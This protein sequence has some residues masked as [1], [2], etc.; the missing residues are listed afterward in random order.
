MGS[1]Y[2]THIDWWAYVGA[3]REY[4]KEVSKSFRIEAYNRIQNAARLR[5]TQRH[6][7]CFPCSRRLLWHRVRVEVRGS[8][9]DIE[10]LQ[11]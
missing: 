5:L 2:G 7:R 3:F 4:G 9:S 10:V 11:Y 6:T 1:W 8:V